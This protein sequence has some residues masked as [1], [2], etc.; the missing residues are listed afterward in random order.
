MADEKTKPIYLT[1]RSIEQVVVEPEDQDRFVTTVQEAARA[2]KSAQDGSQWRQQF[3]A[4]LA[5]IHEWCKQRQD[6]VE[7]GFVDV[8]DG[9]LRVSICVTSE[10]F[11]FDFEDEV[12][13]LDIVLAQKFPQCLS[14]VTQIPRQVAQ[15][16]D[17]SDA[18]VA[19]G[20]TRPAPSAG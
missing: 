11:D 13:E 20:D 17:L 6:R 7:S 10:N 3:E 18:I 1:Y 4:F 14:E 2:C 8:G 9:G 19:Y 5:F 12:T 15:L 16:L